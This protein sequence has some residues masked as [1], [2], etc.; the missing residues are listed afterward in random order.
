M[1]YLKMQRSLMPCGWH[2]AL[3]RADILNRRF[4][5]GR[6]AVRVAAEDEVLA[7]GRLLLPGCRVSIRP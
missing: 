5:A 7:K 4:F 6:G 3:K 2:A 1:E